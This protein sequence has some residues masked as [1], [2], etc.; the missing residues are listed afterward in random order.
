MYQVSFLVLKI[1]IST[2]VDAKVIKRLEA[3]LSKFPA[4]KDDGIDVLSYIYDI[5]E[6]IKFYLLADA[7]ASAAANADDEVSDSEQGEAWLAL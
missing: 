6:K 7:Q 3:E 2:S 5:L 4:W 1:H